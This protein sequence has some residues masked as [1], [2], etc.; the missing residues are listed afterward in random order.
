MAD[1][2][3]T[4]RTKM[5]RLHRGMAVMGIRRDLEDRLK[6]RR[7]DGHVPFIGKIPVFTAWKGNL[8]ITAAA[9]KDM[10]LVKYTA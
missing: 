9:P 3:Q 2:S 5:I 1:S 7:K 10:D 6:F 8:V 4:T